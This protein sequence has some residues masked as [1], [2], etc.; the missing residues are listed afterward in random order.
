MFENISDTIG[1]IAMKVSTNKYITTIKNTFIIIIPF[2][3]VGSIAVLLGNVLFTENYLGGINGLEFL[4][5]TAPL[6]NA[7]NYASMNVMSIMVSFLIGFNLAK[8]FEIDDTIFAGLI[9]L[10]GFIILA[11]TYHLET[12]ESTELLVENVLH[13]DISGAKGLFLAMISGIVL[14]RFYVYL[15]GIDKLK[16]KL[17]ESVPGNVAKSFSS[18][19]PISIIL[20]STGIFGFVFKSITNME[21][22]DMIYSIV[23]TPLESAVQTPFGIIIM[24]FIA[25]ILWFFGIHG[26]SIVNG[27]TDPMLLSALATNSDLVSKGLDPTELIARPSWNMY[28]TLGGS[29]STLP[30]LLAIF[31]FSKREDERAIAKLSIGP[32][33]FGINEPVIFGLPLVFNPIYAI[34]FIFGPVVSVTIGYFATYLGIAAAPYIQVPWSL[35]PFVNAFIAT[36]GDIMTVVVQLVCFIVVFL[37]YTPFVRQSNRQFA[38]ENAELNE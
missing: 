14:T 1:N 26:S 32:G 15:L 11:P 17:H 4:Q 10:A 30:L 16:I 5:N 21:F 35:P 33:L 8:E 7:V 38:E 29:G 22:S 37:L 23:Q 6:F 27:I 19:V 18:L 3:I 31:L 36:G 24:A 20:F 13:V 12:T 9:S 34:P 2:T 25:Q 28:A